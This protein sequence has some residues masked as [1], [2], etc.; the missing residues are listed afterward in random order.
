[1]LANQRAILIWP[2]SIHS[3]PSM[4][5][6]KCAFAIAGLSRKPSIPKSARIAATLP[7]PIKCRERL[8]VLLNYYHQRAA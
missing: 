6:A 4:P 3:E 7:N 1:M 5:I 8:G 2:F